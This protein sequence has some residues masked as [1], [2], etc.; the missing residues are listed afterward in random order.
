MD[1]KWSIYSNVSTFLK[2]D[3]SIRFETLEE[4]QKECDRLA[5]LNPL[6]NCFFMPFHEDNGVHLNLTEKQ[7]EELNKSEK[8]SENKIKELFDS[9]EK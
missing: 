2:L 8:Y 5:G 6:M 7:R 4:C 1:K 3:T 9:F